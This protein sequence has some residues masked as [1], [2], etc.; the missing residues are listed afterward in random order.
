MHGL[1]TEGVH[2]Q[3]KARNVCSVQEKNTDGVYDRAKA[4][5]LFMNIPH[6]WALSKQ[7]SMKRTSTHTDF[8]AVSSAAREN[9]MYSVPAQPE[10]LAVSSVLCTVTDHTGCLGE[11]QRLRPK[12]M[13]AE[14]VLSRVRITFNFL[15]I[16]SLGFFNSGMSKLQLKVL[17]IAGFWIFL[18]LYNAVL[19]VYCTEWQYCIT[20]LSFLLENV[21]MQALQVCFLYCKKSKKWINHFIIFWLKSELAYQTLAIYFLLQTLSKLDYFSL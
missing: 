2:T 9:S 1:A 13:P 20:I 12:M 19:L 14:D 5:V 10:W 4:F 15:S 11:K 18:D 7:K 8:C 17:S 3:T 6:C 21:I 16:M